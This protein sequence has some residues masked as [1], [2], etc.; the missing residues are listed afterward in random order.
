[1]NYVKSILAGMAALV[2]CAF[3]LLVV[4]SLALNWDMPSGGTMSI[5]VISWAKQ[6]SSQSRYQLIALLAFSAGFFSK[7]RRVPK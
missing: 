7:F 2:M 1:M 4:S 6:A 5:D 3:I